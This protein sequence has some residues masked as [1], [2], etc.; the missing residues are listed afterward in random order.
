MSAVI[1]KLETFESFEIPVHPVDL[2]FLEQ[3]HDW[4]SS[5]PGHVK[6]RDTYLAPVS[7]R[8]DRIGLELNLVF[9]FKSFTM[10]LVE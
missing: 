7:G 9:I 5:H 8:L 4:H 1:E 3:I 6:V 2:F 10:L